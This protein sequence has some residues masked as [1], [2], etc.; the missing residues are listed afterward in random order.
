MLAFLDREPAGK[1]CAFWQAHPPRPHTPT[2]SAQQ[3]WD[4]GGAGPLEPRPHLS[5][6]SL[7]PARARPP[8][9]PGAPGPPPPCRAQTNLATPRSAVAVAATG[10]ARQQVSPGRPTLHA[11]REVQAAPPEPCAREAPA[12]RP[13][14]RPA[15]PAARRHAAGEQA[16]RPGPLL[17]PRSCGDQ[18]Q[19]G[20]SHLI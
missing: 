11:S 20:P 4:R 13:L 15:P 7:R 14:R 12:S 18:R 2:S 3:G 6:P 10:R 16:E 8:P 19:P 9:A 17:S 1:V 5:R